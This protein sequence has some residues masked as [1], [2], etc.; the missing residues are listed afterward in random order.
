MIL[1][2]AKK[3]YYALL[4]FFLTSIVHGDVSLC[5]LPQP[6]FIEY[7]DVFFTKNTYVGIDGACTIHFAATVDGIDV[8]VN[9]LAIVCVAQS[10]LLPYVIGVLCVHINDAPGVKELNIV[11]G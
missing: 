8:N 10:V 3:K 11:D 2:I 7:V 1:R 5:F 9:C 4:C 6:L